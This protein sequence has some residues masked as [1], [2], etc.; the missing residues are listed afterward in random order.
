MSETTESSAA[1]SLVEMSQGYFRGKALCA[2]ARLGVAD[3]IGEAEKSLDEIAKATGAPGDSLARLLRALASFGVIRESAPSRFK[4]TP[5]G[6]PLRKDARDSVWASVLFWSDLLADSWTY[7]AECIR[8]GDKSGADLAR[9]GNGDPSRWSIE[10]NAEAIFHAVFAEPAAESMA[11]LAAAYDFSPFQSVADLGGAGGGL[12]AA[13]LAAHG[14]L[15]GVLVDRAGAIERATRRMEA[16][17]LLSRCDLICGD[18]LEGVPSGA[19]LFVLKSVLHGY[20]DDLARRILE[21]C[22]QVIPA[23]GVLL[24]IETVAPTQVDAADPEVE[25]IMMGDLNMLAV[26]GGRERSEPEWRSLF[27]SA[28]FELRR[29]IAVPNAVPRFLEALPIA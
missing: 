9:A 15:R 29:I 6:L 5:L 17:G 13:I 18:L 23:T 2:A 10:P 26:T 21:N 16:A 8:A 11:P 27:A 22:R 1:P 7:L 12:L 20:D 4:L 3:A 24:V 14:R 25:K 19:D 28:R